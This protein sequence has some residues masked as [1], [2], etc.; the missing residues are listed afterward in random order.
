MSED[1][2]YTRLR[3]AIATGVYAPSERLV[4]MDLA[5]SFGVSRSAVRTALAR[6][7]QEN[8]VERLPN[9]GARVRRASEKEIVELLEA[10]M[11]LECIAVRHAAQ[12][13]RPADVT[14]LD[15]IVAEMAAGVAAD[16]PVIYAATNTRFHD[17]IVR[18]ADHVTAAALIENLHSRSAPYQLNV[19]LQP[20]DPQQRLEEHRAIARAIAEHDPDLAEAT[21]RR[22][23]GGVVD[24]MRRRLLRLAGVPG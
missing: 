1:V 4:E 19:D 2:S 22:H 23:L 8:I 21:V 20:R 11:A 18:I 17:E 15:A 9:R 16:D 5:T 24:G 3:E 13:A 6:L 12:N 14:R 7:E 10:R